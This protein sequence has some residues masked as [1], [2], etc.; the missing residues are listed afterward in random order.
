MKKTLILKINVQET[1]ARYF[2]PPTIP[3]ASPVANQ[4]RF[5]PDFPTTWDH[6]SLTVVS[7]VLEKESEMSYSFLDE[8]KRA[9]NCLVPMVDVLTSGA[10]PN[11]TPVRCFWDHHPFTARPVGC[12]IKYV[13]SMIEKSY[14]SSITKEHYFMRGNVTENRLKELNPDAVTV[15]ISPIPRNY[16]LTTGNFCSFNCVVAWI[17]E[18][19]K[20]AQYEDARA[21]LAAMY[22][23]LFGQP[24]KAILPAP[25]WRLLA[26]YGGS[27][28]IDEFRQSFNVFTTSEMMTLTSGTCLKPTATVFKI[29]QQ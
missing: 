25:D 14:I 17:N 16:Y 5:F 4:A 21:L 19:K 6:T 8:K 7:S 20:S 18:H 11:E 3:P 9:V 29:C 26:C 10:L 22:R 13:G 24:M 27:F 15:S 1:L 2:P 23:D 28:S 12:P